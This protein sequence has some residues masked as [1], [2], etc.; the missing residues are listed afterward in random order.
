MK[1]TN[2]MHYEHYL[3]YTIDVIIV[4]TRNLDGI[5]TDLNIHPQAYK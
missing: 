1:S 3:S 2:I 5:T 4:I